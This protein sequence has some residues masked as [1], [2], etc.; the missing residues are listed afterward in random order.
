[1]HNNL[2]EFYFIAYIINKLHDNIIMS[3]EEHISDNLSKDWFLNKEFFDITIVL[4][5]AGMH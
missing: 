3:F 1:M 2:T 4:K 5:F